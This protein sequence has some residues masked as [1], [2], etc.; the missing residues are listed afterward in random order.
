MKMMVK[1]FFLLLWQDSLELS[2]EAWVIARKMKW[3]ICIYLV[4]VIITG[5][6]IWGHDKEYLSK[7]HPD[8]PGMAQEMARTIS[9]W[10]DFPTGIFL[11]FV[12]LYSAGLAMKSSRFRQIAVACLLSAA[13]AGILANCFRL[14]LGRPRPSA[15]AVDGFYGITM[16]SDYQGFPSGHAATGF[17]S[18][19]AVAVA[20]PPVGLP[21]LIVAGSIGWA[22]M[23]LDRHYP[24]DIFV[25]GS[26]GTLFGI[27]F[28]F[29][30]RRCVAREKMDSAGH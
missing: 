26:I 5:L 30:V 18:G 25:G 28:G 15:D 13:M 23:K 4:S 24:S 3:W 9:Y 20:M 27:L 14:T 2:K 11:F 1:K 6:V 29:A 22:R 16:L 17:G 10:G 21:M 7:L 12:L 19:V 8:A